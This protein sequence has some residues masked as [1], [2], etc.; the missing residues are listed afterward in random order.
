MVFGSGAEEKSKLVDEDVY[1]VSEFLSGCVNIRGRKSFNRDIVHQ[2]D[3]LQDCVAY[4]LYMTF[5]RT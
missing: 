5:V 4:R 2:V 1:R 3:A